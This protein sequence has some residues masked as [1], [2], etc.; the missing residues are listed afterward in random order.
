M[1][2]TKRERIFFQGISLSVVSK[3]SG[4]SRVTV[5]RHAYG[6]SEISEKA[7]L[8]YEETLGIN[9]RLLRPDLWPIKRPRKKK[10]EQNDA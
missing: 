5:W 7:A 9:K 6:V 10:E 8:R 1:K 3:L 2:T 4:F